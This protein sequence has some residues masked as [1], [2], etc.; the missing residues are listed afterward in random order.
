MVFYRK[1]IRNFFRENFLTAETKNCSRLLHNIL[2]FGIVYLKKV[3][4]VDKK[5]IL[6]GRLL[7]RFL[8][9]FNRN[10]FPS[11]FFSYLCCISLVLECSLFEMETSLSLIQFYL[12]SSQLD[13][14]THMDRVLSKS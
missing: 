1:N 8:I 14:L 3:M 2:L 9:G 13:H 11:I 7:I 12:F 10:S 5:F 4:L 6:F